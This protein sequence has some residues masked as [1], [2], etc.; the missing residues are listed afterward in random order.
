[1]KGDSDEDHNEGGKLMET[2]VRVDI[3]GVLDGRGTLIKDPDGDA[4]VR[5]DTDVG[6]D[7]TWDLDVRYT[8]TRH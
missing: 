3:N 8:H 1:M 2:D 5:E 4:D 7:H 6:A